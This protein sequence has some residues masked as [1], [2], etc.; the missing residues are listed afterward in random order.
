MAGNCLR[1]ICST[2]MSSLMRKSALEEAGGFERFGAF[3]AEDYFFGV[4]FA[5]R[6]RWFIP[7]YCRGWRSVISSLPALQNGARPDPKKFRER[8]C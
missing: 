4:A 7:V 3:L 1:F 2:G 5:K 6:F 8:I